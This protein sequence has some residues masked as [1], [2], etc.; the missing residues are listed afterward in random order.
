MVKG[1]LFRNNSSQLARRGSASRDYISKIDRARTRCSLVVTTL[2]DR[3]S[4]SRPRG[5]F[6][7]S[8]TV[9]LSGASRAS[10]FPRP[11]RVVVNTKPINIC[12]VLNDSRDCAMKLVVETANNVAKLILLAVKYKYL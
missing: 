3:Q 6:S 5:P 4:L 9:N 2:R 10:P 11:C 8:L 7:V 12:S 1:G